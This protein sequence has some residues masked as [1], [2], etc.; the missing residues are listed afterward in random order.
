MSHKPQSISVAAETCALKAEAERTLPS[1]IHPERVLIV[2]PVGQDAAAMAA[3]LETERFQTHIC[4]GLSEC[5]AQIAH[6][7]SAL[8]LTEEAL[9]LPHL[10][11]LLRTL[12]AQ[13]PW[14]E[15]PVIILTRG[16]EPRLRKLLDLTAAAARSTTLLERPLGT[17]TLLR[18]VQVALNSR[19]RQYQVRALLEEQERVHAELRKAQAELQQHAAS[20]ELIVAERTATLRETI[21]ELESYSY[22]ISHDMRAPLRAM[23]AYAQFL[24]EELRPSLD[25]SHS[26]YLDR[27]GTAATR[28]DKLI[29]DVLSYSRVS[30]AEL[31]LKAV[32]LDRLVREIA[33]QYP[34]LQ[35][36]QIHIANDLGSVL[37]AETLLTQAIANL[38]TNAAKFVTAGQTPRIRVWSEEIAR[39]S[40]AA[41]FI[42]LCIQD[43][44]IGI[45]ADEQQRIFAIFARG[46][47]EK[48]YEGTGIGLSIV[49]KAIERMHGEVG[50]H[51]MLGQGSTFWIQLPKA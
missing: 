30:R 11:E 2:A 44:G 4:A 29:T 45:S 12:E 36:A 27:I 18:S 22:S 20:L 28:L 25:A 32:N 48:E 14:S 35:E 16:G 38:L 17:A 13:P 41:P 6:G 31:E 47:S 51:S 50:V 42:R 8:L 24:L 49:K 21:H 19:R 26:R 1:Q 39:D 5:A 43:N 33:Y 3:L 9:E 34:V 23:Q 7:A 15:L 37:A 40:S 10:P 46:H